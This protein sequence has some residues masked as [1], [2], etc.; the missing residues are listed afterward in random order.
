MRTFF[1]EVNVSNKDNAKFRLEVNDATYKFFRE[2]MERNHYLFNVDSLVSLT[3][4]FKA[5]EAPEFELRK[6]Q[7]Q[8]LQGLI[9]LITDKE[10]LFL[11][12]DMIQIIFS[13]EKNNV[14]RYKFRIQ[15]FGLVSEEFDFFSIIETKF[16]F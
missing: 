1:I 9:Q 5:G 8:E 2:I 11:S 6:T 12:G 10:S 3:E 7:G 14:A 13:K 16:R 4:K 15:N